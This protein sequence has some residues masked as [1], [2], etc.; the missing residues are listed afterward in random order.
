MQGNY[1]KVENKRK[2]TNIDRE[3]KI[4]IIIEKEEIEKRNNKEERKINKYI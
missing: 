3:T 1:D 2:K 4:I